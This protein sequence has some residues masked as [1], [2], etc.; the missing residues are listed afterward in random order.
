[1]SPSRVILAVL[2]AGL[3]AVERKAFLQAMISR[4]LIA[5]TLIGLALGEPGAG[6]ALGAALELFFLGGVNLGAPLPDNEL[7]SAVAAASCGC[8]LAQRSSLPVTA[9]LA[10]AVL[11]SLPLAKLGKYGDEVSERVNAWAAAH[12]ERQGQVKTRLRYNLF[13]LW[14]PFAMTAAAAGTGIALGALVL[15]PLLA[16]GPAKLEWG[17]RLAWLA[18]LMVAAAV[19]LRSIRSLRA[20]VF[21]FFAAVLATGAQAVRLLL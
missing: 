6:L 2:I 1:M 13:G 20:G 3:L 9:A 8:A 15:P 19:A 10:V 14:M 18:F 11:V 4:P 16:H 17:L 12:A 5:G 21:A 7:L